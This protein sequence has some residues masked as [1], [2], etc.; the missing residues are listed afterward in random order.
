MIQTAWGRAGGRGRRVKRAV[1][2]QVRGFSPSL[3]A[4]LGGAWCYFRQG[5]RFPGE[6]TL[7][8]LLNDLDADELD[9]Q[10]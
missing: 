3:L 8:M 9:R 6:K 4:R 7:R 10:G 5:Y 1:E 2:R